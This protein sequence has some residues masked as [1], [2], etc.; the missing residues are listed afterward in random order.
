MT[1]PFDISELLE[2]ILLELPVEDL[3]L[4]TSLNNTW[5]AAIYGSIKI[6]KRL[7]IC[8]HLA[9]AEATS[10]FSSSAYRLRRANVIDMVTSPLIQVKM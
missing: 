4:T 10:R 1:T 2:A 7:L 8:R 9:S 6:R 5:R 3:I